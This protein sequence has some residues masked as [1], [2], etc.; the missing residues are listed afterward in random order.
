MHKPV[1]ENLHEIVIR[2]GVSIHTHKNDSS[3]CSRRIKLVVSAFCISFQR[4]FKACHAHGHDINTRQYNLYNA[5]YI[6]INHLQ[7]HNACR[8]KRC[9]SK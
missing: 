2:G 5:S 8:K 7:C 6:Q 4:S 1:K 3:M 9:P